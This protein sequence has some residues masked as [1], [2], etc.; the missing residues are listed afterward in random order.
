MLNN[1]RKIIAVLLSVFVFPGVGH[2][3]LGK[4][5][6]GWT[7]IILTIVCLVLLFMTVIR[8]LS[9]SVMQDVIEGKIGTSLSAVLTYALSKAAV[10]S[11]GIWLRSRIMCGCLLLL[12]LISLIHIIFMVRVQE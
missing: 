1:K 4:K 10:L 6:L 9:D 7:M 8:S 12:W 5:L 3:Y 11:S 2:L